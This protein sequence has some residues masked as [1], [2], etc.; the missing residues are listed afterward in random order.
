MKLLSIYQN[1]VWVSQGFCILFW[2]SSLWLG[3]GSSSRMCWWEIE[4]CE[5]RW[6]AEEFR[7][8]LASRQCCCKFVFAVK[9]AYGKSCC[10]LY[11]SSE[12]P[13]CSCSSA[14]S[15]VCESMQQLQDVRFVMLPGCAHRVK[16]WHWYLLG[17][18]LFHRFGKEIFADE[19]VGIEVELV[20]ISVQP[21]LI[22][23][24]QWIARKTDAD[25]S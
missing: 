21:Y 8:C 19:K 17:L 15:E 13:C 9:G 12:C 2:S 14:P 5:R 6:G 22:S 20:S 1:F 3:G 16:E 24:F 25:P 23:W 18:G 10:S 11:P 4:Q 7:S